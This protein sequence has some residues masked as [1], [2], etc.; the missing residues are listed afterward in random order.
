MDSPVLPDLIDQI[1]EDETI[2]IVTADGAYDTRR[3]HAAIIERDAVPIIP[4]RRNGRA[5][6]EDCI[7]PVKSCSCY[8]EESSNE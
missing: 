8:M 1:P 2:C 7:D 5:W 3:C 4:I 6:T